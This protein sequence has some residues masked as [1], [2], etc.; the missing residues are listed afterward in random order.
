MIAPTAGKIN[1][2]VMFEAHLVIIIQNP[3]NDCQNLTR[4]VYNHIIQIV[5]E[6]E[7]IKFVGINKKL[8]KN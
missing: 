7:I 5:S 3:L 2:L 4:L 6:K 1:H 8:F